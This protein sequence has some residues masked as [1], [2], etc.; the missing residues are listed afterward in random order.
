MKA[1]ITSYIHQSLPASVEVAVGDHADCLSQLRLY[2][3][4][5]RDHQPH[6]LL[7]DRHNLFS[8]QFVVALLVDPI[9]LNE[10]LEEQGG[11]QPSRL[12]HLV[13]GDEL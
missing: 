3:L 2:R 6:E 7:L 5:D 1:I 10:V 11:G 9:A 4:W 12:G 8:W 13:G